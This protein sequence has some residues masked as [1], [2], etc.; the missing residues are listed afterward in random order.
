[1][2]FTIVR[3]TIGNKTIYIQQEKFENGYHVGVNKLN[4]DNVTAY[5]VNDN[6]YGDIKKAKK[7][8]SYL[9]SQVKKGCYD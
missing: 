7:R 9:K 6:Y 4:S 2:T 8:Y 3:E 1:M 5:N